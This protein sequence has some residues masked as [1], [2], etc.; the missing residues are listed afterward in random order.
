MAEY[1]RDTGCGRVVPGLAAAD[2]LEA[3]RLLRRDYATCRARAVEVGKRDF[4]QETLVAA[5][6]ELYHALTR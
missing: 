4:S 3:I 2:L 5:H 1:V 6:R